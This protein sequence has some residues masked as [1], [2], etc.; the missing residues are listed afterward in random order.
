MLK[1]IRV[2][3]GNMRKIYITT[4]LNIVHL[5]LKGIP[6]GI[7]FLVLL[8]LLSPHPQNTIVRLTLLCAG[9]A[10]VMLI[11]LFVAVRVHI[12]AYLTGYNLATQAR[13]TLGDHLR[14]LS[15]GFFKQRDPGDISALLLQDMAKVEQIFSMFFIDASAC[16]VLPLMMGIFF[17]FVDWRLTVL[18]TAAVLVAVPALAFSQKIIHHFGKKQIDSRNRTGSRMLEYLQGIKVLK[19]FNL[20]G[21]NFKRLDRTM[22]Q[23]CSDSIKLEAAAGGPVLVYMA[24]LELGFVALLVAGVH[25]FLDNQILLQVL[26]MFLVLGY[27]FFEPLINFGTFISGMRYMNLAASRITEVLD[28][29]VLKEPELP[30]CP[31]T[32]DIAFDQVGFGYTNSRVLSGLTIRFPE[33]KLTALVGP[34]G[35]GKTTI[36][37]LVARF[38]DVDAGRIS[39][40]GIDIRQMPT[41]T[42]N[43]MLSVVFQDVYLFQDTIYNNIL[44]GKKTASRGEVIA[45]AKTAQCH[46]FIEKMAN[47]YDT[48]VGEGGTT[49]SGGERQRISIARAILKDAP[50]VLLD[51]ATASLDPENERLIQKAIGEMIRSKTVVVIAH[52]LK[53]IAGADRILVID[54]GQVREKG[55]HAELLSNADLYARLWNEQQR[56]GGWKFGWRNGDRCISEKVPYPAG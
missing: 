34:S 14:K 20:T 7:L 3:A 40:G 56:T 51:E 16:V 44:V 33:K 49:L 26:L 8:E 37:S 2:I 22:R 43:G 21:K 35:S 31:Q 42:L 17:A 28:T 48:M 46:T 27:K 13:L 15:L 54:G 9:V 4:L 18:M 24:I 32:F 45:A 53:T 29:P 39:I 19:A 11:N 25:L 50:I 12:R 47:G 36:T 55:T 23:L 30:A 6:F 38:W 10:M 52:R 41:E 1:S 5:I